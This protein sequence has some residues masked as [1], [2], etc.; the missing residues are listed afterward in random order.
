MAL[1]IQS[2]IPGIQANRNL[3]G[4]NRSMRNALQKLSSGFRINQAKDGPAALVISELLRSQVSG[5]ERAVRNTQEASNM[6][7]IAEGGLAG[8][9]GQLSKMRQLALHALNSGV[10]SS[11]QVAADQGEID[12]ALSTIDR[13]ANTT[14]HAE[15]FLL[16]GSQGVTFDL[17]DASGIV[18]RSLTQID[19][20]ADIAGQTVQIDFSGNVADQAEK[21]FLETDFG[22]GA[23]TFASTQQF[24]VTGD[25]GASEFT[26]AAGT[27]I[28]DAVDQINARSDLT[29]IEAFAIN[30]AGAGAT[31]IRL[32]SEAFGTDA[33]VQVEQTTG[34]GFA[35]AGERA[36]DTGQNAIVNIDGQRVE[37]DG[38]VVD[39][40]TQNV[41]GSITLN[42]AAGG[43][44]QTGYDQDKGALVDA[45][46]PAS[47]EFTNFRGGMR[48]QLGEGGG[49]QNRDIFGL[50]SFDPAN[51]GRIQVEGESFS[52]ADIRGGGRA[53]LANDPAT[54]LR[55]IDQAISDVASSR[56][57][58][59]A[60]QANTLETNVNALNIAIENVT[61]T[62]SAIRDADMAAEVTA[63]VTAQ[64]LEKAGLM[65]VQSANA[66]AQNVLR[67]LG[68]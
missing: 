8:V 6:L 60:Y 16:N 32:V 20:K 58:I 18:N 61:A 45:A 66:N 35:A 40:A 43:V 59:G 5:F 11:Q 14:R 53:S 17:A 38:L 63:F 57:R 24:T 9:S 41:S 19:E 47:A 67:L 54:A 46:A 3:L 64:I 28:Q 7:G 26:F 34:D 12:S 55:V 65:G 13:V 51:L 52:L 49:T 33:A 68:G 44:A 25:K 30:D 56:A 1:R 21:A 36:R 37:G 31:E 4:A 42:E 48:F 62:E 15:N 10:T 22:S 50:G 27:S 23:T 29:G 39:L 2:N